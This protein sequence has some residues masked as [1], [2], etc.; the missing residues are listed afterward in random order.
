MNDFNDCTIGDV[1]KAIVTGGTPNT[2]VHEYY[3]GG[4]IPWLKTKEV[5]FCRIDNTENFIT[6]KGLEKSSAKIVPPDS[7]IVAMYGQGDTAGRVALNTIPLTTNQACC[8][9][10]IDKEIADSKF[11]FYYLW[12]S[13]DE[14]VSRKTGSAQPNLNT[15]LIRSLEISIPPLPEQKAIASVL[16]SLD[17]KID[18]LHRQT[19]TLESMAETLFR[20]W[21]VEEA[22]ESCPIRKLGDFITTNQSSLS[23]KTDV[24][25]ID[26]LDT[27]SLTDGKI[28]QLQS[29]NFSEAPSRAKRL[30]KHNDILISTVRPNQRHYGIIKNPSSNLVVST[31]FC[32]ITCNKI[33]PHFV[34]L[35][36]IQNDMTEYLHSIAE[37]STSTYPSLKPSDIET[38]DLILPPQDKMNAF[39]SISS[40]IWE[41]IEYNY[42][43]INTLQSLR[44]TLLPKLMSGEVRVKYD[45]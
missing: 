39:A 41:K 4:T 33:D 5:N 7:I 24:E 20:R 28:D 30:V 27:G 17:D 44:D 31:G 40:D 11:I 15:K 42:S 35:F 14:L 16:S 23:N 25:L 10:I 6:K 37:G 19:K 45:E 21:F 2:K 22:D 8:N 32:V 13:Y 36:L 3:K 43:Q 1:C 18:L 12:N 38:L 9:L 26:Y 29:T 34:Y